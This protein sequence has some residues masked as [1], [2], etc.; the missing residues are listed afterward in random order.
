MSL[1]DYNDDRLAK[2]KKRRRNENPCILCD[3]PTYDWDYMCTPCRKSWYLGKKKQADD[4]RN[5]GRDK[6]EQ[7]PIF[8]YW[9]FFYG[10]VKDKREHLDRYKINHRIR[11]AAISLAGGEKQEFDNH[12][13]SKARTLG[14]L[15]THV[16]RPGYSG[17]GGEGST[18]YRFP[19]RGTWKLLQDLTLAIRDLSNHHYNK[20]YMDGSN[21]LFR[22]SS[23]ELTVDEINERMTGK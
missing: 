1:Y 4:A 16:G 7:V 15:K 22:I 13:H 8:T 5:I 6:T 18:V 17:G 12:F 19:R 21:L 14:M 10:W 9:S 20:G 3:E 2:N 23:G 11:E